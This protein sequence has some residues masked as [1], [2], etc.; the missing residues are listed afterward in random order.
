M[1]PSICLLRWLRLL[2]VREFSLEGVFYLWDRV[3][4]HPLPNY[5]VLEYVATAILLLLETPIR[6]CES[7][8][9][10]MTLLQDGCHSLN[11][12]TVWEL[13][14]CL[15]RTKEA[16]AYEAVV[17]A[18][19]KKPEE[20]KEKAFSLRRL[21]HPPRRVLK[22]RKSREE[23]PGS[24]KSLSGAFPSDAS[25]QSLSALSQANPSSQSLTALS[26]TNP[27]SQSLSALSQTNPS[28][29]SLS[30]LSL[31]NASSRS[32][33]DISP[34]ITPS[35]SFNV[36]SLNVQPNFSPS[37]PTEAPDPSPIVNSPEKPEDAIQMDAASILSKYFHSSV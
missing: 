11:V 25:S 20:K 26:Q 22:G 13:A 29:Q 3:L 34:S 14:L 4:V 23:S 24:A 9:Q 21:F 17:V 10:L 37:T 35:E 28:S 8:Q 36:A 18:S 32:L 16:T 6:Q 15:W 7:I 5:P 33:D 1:H 12:R 31:A 19:E 30:A 27:S 2:F